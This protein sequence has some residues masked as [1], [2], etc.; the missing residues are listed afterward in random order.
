M[1]TIYDAGPCV[2][3]PYELNKAI[4]GPLRESATGLTKLAHKSGL[5]YEAC[6][7]SI[8]STT[9]SRYLQCIQLILR[10][11]FHTN[12]VEIDIGS[13]GPYVIM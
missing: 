13:C 11:V 3:D 2:G 1:G 8:I 7:S 6:A 12:L 5:L 9:L 4:I 10:V